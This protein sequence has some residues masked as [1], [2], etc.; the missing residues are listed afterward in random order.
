MLDYQIRSHHTDD[1]SN[2]SCRKRVSKTA[3]RV[4]RL[5]LQVFGISFR[6]DLTAILPSLVNSGV[7]LIVICKELVSYTLG[8]VVSGRCWRV[9]VLASVLRHSP[10]VHAPA[11]VLLGV[12]LVV[13][14]VMHTTAGSIQPR[15]DISAYQT[16]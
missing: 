4:S 16:N 14:T 1:R 6:L 12:L 15:T 7:L 5:E 10:P 8:R 2:V 3:P 13:M 11:C 9:Y